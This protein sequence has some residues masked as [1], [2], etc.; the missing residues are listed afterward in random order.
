VELCLALVGEDGLSVAVLPIQQRP[1]E[2]L[3]QMC[4]AEGK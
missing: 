1:L 3:R 2:L 4:S